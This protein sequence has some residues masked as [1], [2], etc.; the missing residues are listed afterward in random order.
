MWTIT[1]E[2]Y[3]IDSSQLSEYGK[4]LVDEYFL[5]SKFSENGEDIYLLPHDIA[6]NLTY[7]EQ[8]ALQLPPRYNLNLYITNKGTVTK[9]MQYEVLLQDETGNE[10]KEYL[11][12]GSYIRFQNGKE[13]IL[14]SSHYGIFDI[15]NRYDKEIV[16]KQDLD[17]RKYQNFMS[18]AE[19]QAL[20]TDLSIGVS[21]TIGSKPVI[22]PGK[23][24]IMIGP[25]DDETCSFV[26][27]FENASIN[28]EINN[29]LHKRGWGSREKRY[30][31]DPEQLAALKTIE[32][33]EKKF[34]KDK[35]ERIIK[36][37]DN[38][39]PT[40]GETLDI[41]KIDGI[42]ERVTGIGEFEGRFIPTEMMHTEWIPEGLSGI[43]RTGGLESRE[44]HEK[45]LL[46]KN[47]LDDSDVF[48]TE[49][50]YPRDKDDMTIDILKPDI[51]LKSYQKKGVSYLQELWIK[52]YKGA[53]LAD[54]MGL[55]KTL[56]TLT[57]LA[58][59]IKHDQ[60]KVKHPILIVAP[61]SL[62]QNWKDECCKFI[63]TSCG[64]GEP[65]IL[66]G[67]TLDLFK[68]NTPPPSLLRKY[69]QLSEDELKD[70]AFL[71]TDRICKYSLVI[72]NY[73]TVRK[74]Q[75]SLG[76][77]KWNMLILDEA[78][79]IKNPSSRVSHAVRGMNY[80]FG[81]A[82]TGTPVENSWVDLWTIMDFCSS[83]RFG[84]LQ[85]FNK[86]YIKPVSQSAGNISVLEK[87]G[88]ELKEKLKPL[89]LRR[90][91]QDV[92]SELPVKHELVRDRYMSDYQ[93]A[94]YMDIVNQ[95]GRA[96]KGSFEQ[97]MQ[98]RNV[99]IHPYLM[100]SK[101]KFLELPFEE[102]LKV[103]DKLQ[104]L[105]ETLDDIK[106]KGEKALIFVRYKKLQE[107]IR[108]LCKERYGVEILQPIN[109]DMKGERRQATVN[110]FNRT[111]GFNVLILSPEAG[112]VGLNITSAN[113]VIHL[114]REWN[115]A[116]EDQS[117]DRAYRIG[118]TKDVYV[119]YPIAKLR[120]FTHPSFD[121]LQH[122]LLTRKRELSRS[123]IV[124]NSASETEGAA[125]FNSIFNKD[126][127]QSTGCIETSANRDMLE[128]Y[129]IDNVARILKAIYLKKGYTIEDGYKDE[130]VNILYTHN[131]EFH[132]VILVDESKLSGITM[133]ARKIVSEIK[134]SIQRR[135]HINVIKLTICGI[136]DIRKEQIEGLRMD[137]FFDVILDMRDI[138]KLLD[139]NNICVSDYISDL[140]VE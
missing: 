78:Q 72:T 60:Y 18:I 97:L 95:T 125:L 93:E 39:F 16:T 118:Q 8:N 10:T 61:V 54:D 2:E 121:E 37:A 85:A 53:L 128:M 9:E 32:S 45:V 5:Y 100:F 135:K 43:E 115:P 87:K 29:S 47:N 55:G 75:L 21:E 58:W 7:E 17:E 133:H 73:E 114:S 56:Q 127:G 67:V 89:L 27:D 96:N 35:A 19:I 137:Q 101:K 15:V 105:F 57:F 123:V 49:T 94:A 14:P 25:N 103:S 74:Y 33:I 90:M 30:A 102:H 83:D 66:H 42:S 120:H 116:K 111:C 131:N 40:D 119:Y 70:N 71:N 3:E 51:T 65:L 91:K 112:G 6:V 122:E 41:E 11:R 28:E 98:L 110:E 13:Y 12:K 76:V 126:Y 82:L 62:L 48:I 124:P 107:L 129:G 99:S 92:L 69:G 88:L 64:I 109:G 38:Y 108:K 50:P 81:L 68:L 24:S 31:F 80:N 22:S 117:T 86:E 52:G 79:N 36:Q 104:F 23:M 136:G 63:D 139:E 1:D 84:T 34:T 138:K 26:V 113:H 140:T 77:I 132:G 130:R 46:I 4:Q 20:S 106:M 134:K 44:N 59:R